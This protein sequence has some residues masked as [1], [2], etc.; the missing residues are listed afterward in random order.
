MSGN[1]LELK[2]IGKSFGGI[3]IL[4]DIDFTVERGTFHAL[5]G[6]N[7]A[8]KSTLMKIVCGTYTMDQG[9]YLYDGQIIKN[10]NPRDA[11]QMGI[12]MIQQ[13]LSPIPE[14]TIAEN[15]FLYREP[16]TKLR[17]VDDKKDE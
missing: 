10:L 15:I 12:S 13:E 6:E 7:G 2:H 11:I 8:G 3:P 14:M 17:F 4:K 1:V 5:L 16:M 9:E